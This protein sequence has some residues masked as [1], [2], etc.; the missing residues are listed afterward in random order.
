MFAVSIPNF[1]TS[2]AFVETA[3]KCFATDFSSPP[4][5]ASD[6]SRAVWALVIVSRV[7]KVFEATMKMVSAGSRS[8]TASAKSV[9]SMLETNRKVIPLSVIS[10]RLIGHNRAE[11]GTADPDVD[12]VSNALARVALPSAASDAVTKIGHFVE[13]CVDIGH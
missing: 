6:Q 9:P 11:I 7:P 10:E 2:T 3:T 4:R 8:R 13:H 12:H 5:P 1:A